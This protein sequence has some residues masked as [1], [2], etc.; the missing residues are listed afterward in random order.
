MSEEM[1]INDISTIHLRISS[2]RAA[3]CMAV[4]DALLN[5]RLSEIV[6]QAVRRDDN[7]K[8]THMNLD[9]E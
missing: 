5:E 1:T 3:L 8:Q 6:Q 2:R 4:N 9:T 7:N